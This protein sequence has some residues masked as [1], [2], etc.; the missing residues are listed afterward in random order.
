[1]PSLPAEQLLAGFAKVEIAPPHPRGM[2]LLGMGRVYPGAQGVL[3]PIHAR[4]CYVGTRSDGALLLVLDTVFSKVLRPH[5]DEVIAELERRTGLPAARIWILCTHCHSSFG[6][7]FD[8][9]WAGGDHYRIRTLSAHM[10]VLL[11]RLL[12]VG[13]Q[14]FERRVPAEIGYASAPVT[15]VGSSRRVRTA[16]GIALSAWAHGPCPPPGMRPIGRGPHDP[17]LGLVVFRDLRRHRP[18]GALVNYSSHIHLYPTLNFTA[19]L[20]GA[21][22]RRLERRHRGLL[23]IYTNGAEGTVSLDRFLP[24]QSPRPEDWDRQYRR[25]LERLSRR[26]LHGIEA[27][28]GQLAFRSRVRLRG[29]D[30]SVRMRIQDVDGREVRLEQPLKALTIDD[31]AL[32]GEQEEA[33]CELALGIKARSPFPSTFVLGFVGFRNRYFP[34]AH[35][36]EEGGYESQIRYRDGDGFERTIAGAVQLLAGLRKEAI[37]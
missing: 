32:V 3:D 25:E 5:Q 34:T 29:G 18:I 31:L 11:P 28:W 35:G 2:S 13:T 16:D 22:V 37:R 12:A 6:E 10:E 19:E 24:P 21:V 14:A 8:E 7:S 33:W 27:A 9:T 4:A 15:D 30:R 17:D 26:M 20:A 23:T 36:I 1:M